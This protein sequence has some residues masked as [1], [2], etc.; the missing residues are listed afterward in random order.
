[1]PV[2]LGQRVLARFRGGEQEFP[3]T[4][5]ACYSDNTYAIDYDDGT[6]SNR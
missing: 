2:A 4:I 6:T 1:M 3:G 5:S